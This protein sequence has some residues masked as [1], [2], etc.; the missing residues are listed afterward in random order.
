MGH[1]TV[2]RA[3]GAGQTLE[4]R[5]SVIPQPGVG[6]LSLGPYASPVA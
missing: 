3:A 5:L 4:R 6:C 1:V 2:G